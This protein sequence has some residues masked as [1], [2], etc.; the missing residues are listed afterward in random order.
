MEQDLEARVRAIELARESM[1]D[2]SDEKARHTLRTLALGLVRLVEESPSHIPSGIY[3]PYPSAM[4]DVWICN[5][6]AIDS[7]G[8]V[9]DIEDHGVLDTPHA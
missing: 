2:G 8:D 6:W 4:G 1:I 7:G 3:G 9:Y 5:K